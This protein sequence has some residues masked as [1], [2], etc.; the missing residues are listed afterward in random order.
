VQSELEFATTEQLQTL[1]INDLLRDAAFYYLDWQQAFLEVQVTRNLLKLAEQRNTAIE[2]RVRSGDLARIVETEFKTTLLQRQSALLE[3][4]Q[5]LAASG[6]KLSLYRRNQAGE[7]VAPGEG[8]SPKIADTFSQQLTQQLH[9]LPEKMINHPQLQALKFRR[10]QLEQERKLAAT[11]LLPTL[12]MDVWVANDLGDGSETLDGLESYIGV[13]FSVPLERRKAKGK[14][15]AVEAK[16]RALNFDQ[17]QTQEIMRNFVATELM[18]IENLTE[19]LNLQKN[20]AALAIEL[21]DLEQK[22]FAAGDSDLFLLNAREIARAE[23]ELT[24]VKTQ[25]NIM[26]KQINL[27]AE[28]ALLLPIAS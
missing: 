7:P 10:E 16:I 11:E 1:A 26:R 22:R 4:Q 27:L 17:Q 19:L 6:L 21:A 20:Q 23:A 5:K 25:I 12:D 8:Q 18:G 15:Q 3:K 28:A 2:A 24:V 9:T 14:L 13:N